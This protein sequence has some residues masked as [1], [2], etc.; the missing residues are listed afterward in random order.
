MSDS[1]SRLTLPQ[2]EIVFEGEVRAEQ[3]VVL[4]GRAPDASWLRS[5]ALG[6]SVWAVDRGAWAC[7]NAGVSPIYALGD[8]DSIADEDRQ[9]LEHLDVKID[10]YPADKD[11]TDFQLCL[12]RAGGNLL[13]T[14]CWGGRFD[15]AFANVFSI[16][17]GCEWGAKVRAFA[18]ESEV[19]IPLVGKTSIELEFR[20]RPSVVSLLPLSDVC[21]GVSLRGTK[22]EL[23]DAEI[24]LKRPYTVSNV[25]TED[26]VQVRL[27]KG[28]LGVYCLFGEIKL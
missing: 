21:E 9:W 7:R 27:E 18:D 28:S 11:Y 3:L 20:A 1:V 22:W 24:F 19:L 16:P 10:R 17:W 12:R 5:V 2:A 15:H 8:F 23:N 25:P 26:R 4:G 13:V 14:G 6:K